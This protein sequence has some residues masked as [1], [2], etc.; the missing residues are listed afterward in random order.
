MQRSQQSR[1]H[2]PNMLSQ[3]LQTPSHSSPENYIYSVLLS[4]IPAASIQLMYFLINQFISP[5]IVGIFFYALIIYSVFVIG[6][7]ASYVTLSSLMDLSVYWRSSLLTNTFVF[8]FMIANQEV[9]PSIITFG[10][11]LMCLSFFHL[12]EFV[13]TVLYNQSE[14]TLDSFLLNHSRE[15][16]LAMLVSWVEFFLE[17]L[18]APSIKINLY[19]RFLGLFLVMFGELFRKLAM[20]TAGTNF[21]HYVQERR[22]DDHILVKTGIYSLVRHP[23][24]FGWFWWSIG[25]QVLLCNPICVV[26][27]GISSWKFFKTRIAYEEFHLIKFFGK[28]YTNYQKKVWTG[29]PFVSGYVLYGEESLD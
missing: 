26:L 23:S 2:Q 24:Y 20:I 13:T 17:V 12:S 27:Y 28:E 18:I 14:V 16:G 1:G 11:Y 5:E 4:F 10:Y 25:T 19:V 3:F 9:Y 22:K 29:I 6:N 21:N 15:Y 8:G 7:I